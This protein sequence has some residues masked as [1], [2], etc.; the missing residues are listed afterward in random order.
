MSNRIKGS[1]YLIFGISLNSKSNP[2]AI[3]YTF[4][5]TRNKFNIFLEE[6]VSELICSLQIKAR[7]SYPFVL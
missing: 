2:L 3:R 1:E 5:S 7:I 6:I 4:R